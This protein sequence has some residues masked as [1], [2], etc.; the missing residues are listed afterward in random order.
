MEY[1]EKMECTV[2][3]T[4][5]DIE[6]NH[7]IRMEKKGVIQ[8]HID[9]LPLMYGRYTLDVAIHSKDSIEIYDDIRNVKRFPNFSV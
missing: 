3:G 2:F 9:Y 4:N 7:L 1:L 6:T 5:I 8:V